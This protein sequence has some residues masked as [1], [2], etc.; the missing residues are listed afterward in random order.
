MKTNYDL[1]F[2]TH[3]P[4]FYKVNLYNTLSKRLRIFVI[5]IGSDS[6]IRT[7]DFS[8]SEKNFE[9]IVL[10]H[11]PFETRTKVITLFKLWR[12]LHHLSYKRLIVGGWEL[13]EF[14]LSVLLSPKRLNALAL[15]SPLNVN[16]KRGRQ[17]LKHLFIKR[18]SCVYASGEAQCAALDALG[19]DGERR[20]TG[21]VGLMH[22]LQLTQPKRSS[23]ARKFLYVGRFSKEKNIMLLLEAFKET[24]ECELTCIGGGP[25][26]SQMKA[27]APSNVLILDYMPNSNLPNTFLEHDVLILPSLSEA[28]GLI[29]EEAQAAGLP[30]I[31]SSEVGCRFERVINLETGLVFKSNDLN[32]LVQSIRAMQKEEV[33]LAC[34]QALKEVN[35]EALREAQISSYCS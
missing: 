13:P 22:H 16:A 11:G 17:R 21:G 7:R 32:S 35:F 34:A 24:T 1:V 26:F 20:V 28:W 31:V 10:Q 12:C 18:L 9:H 30:V 19:Y 29:I 25:L 27:L 4:A 33:Y 14:W 15:E 3:V 23:V 5:F 6:K 2:I 8:S